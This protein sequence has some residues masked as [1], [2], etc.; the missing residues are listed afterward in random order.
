MQT[1]KSVII[2]CAGIGSRLGLGTT[3]ALI[4][5][6][7]KTL[8]HW[9]L[10]LFRD[11][12][13]IRIVVGFEA[14]RVVEEVRKYRPDAI[15]VY[16]HDYFNTKTGTS[17]Y[18]GAKDGNEYA[19]EYD[20]D[21]LVHPDDVKKLLDTGGE[22]I[23]YADKRSEDAV[24]LSLNEDGEVTG[25]SRDHGDYEWT[26]PCC[27]KKERV[28]YTSGNVFNVLEPYIPLPGI[29]IRACDIDTYGDYQKAMEFI[30]GWG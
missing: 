29:K 30:K 4:D 3:K 2:T 20:G 28:Q 16:N 19:M 10:D 21:L 7:G 6:N 27:L 11:V 23:A 25:F 13:D 18:L 1:A 22:W 9:Q 5:I 12:E 8:I 24:Y 17:Y 14:N 26:G 15:F